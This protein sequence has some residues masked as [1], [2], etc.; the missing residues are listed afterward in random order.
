M[1]AKA[2]IDV[3]DSDNEAVY[4]CEAK[5]SAT[6]IPYS[7]TLKMTVYCKLKSEFYRKISENSKK[8]MMLNF[9]ISKF[10]W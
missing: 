7:R 2:V 4:K 9:I 10:Y 6:S 3:G 1:T 5:N 8:I